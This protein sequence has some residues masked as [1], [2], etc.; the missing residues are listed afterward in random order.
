MGDAEA[1]LKLS[2]WDEAGA[3]PQ[4][5][6][7]AGVSLPVGSSGF[8]SGHA[9]PSFRFSLSLTLSDRVGL[10]YNAGFEWESAGGDATGSETQ[11]SFIYTAAVGVGLT[12]RIGVFAE[13]FGDLPAGDDGEGSH[14]LDGGVTLLLSGDLQLDV[15][16]GV[17]VSGA[18]P[19]WFLGMGV[20]LRLR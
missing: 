11:A 14:S 19:D 13:A 2:L 3:R 1:G 20:S 17:A 9:D 16:A 7:L 10:G 15:A 4:A 8:S 12:D 18:A 6:L 5:A